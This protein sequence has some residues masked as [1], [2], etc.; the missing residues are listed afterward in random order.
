MWYHLQY[1]WRKLQN[2]GVLVEIWLICLVIFGVDLL[3]IV[4]NCWGVWDLV[5]VL[6]I[7]SCRFCQLVY[8]FVTFLLP[9]YAFF[10]AF[11]FDLRFK[12]LINL[13]AGNFQFGSSPLW[14]SIFFSIKSPI[15]GSSI[16]QTLTGS[17]ILKILVDF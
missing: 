4:T 2:T 13:N 6:E 8:K 10:V 11:F 9:I 7:C 17:S 5:T 3:L 12:P 1:Y 14:A 16:F 15:V